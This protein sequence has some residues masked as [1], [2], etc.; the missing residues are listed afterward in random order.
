MSVKTD[1]EYMLVREDGLE[2]VIFSSDRLKEVAVFCNIPYDTSKK[3]KCLNR[4][5]NFEGRP[6]KIIAVDLKADYGE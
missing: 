5:F 1:Y 3:N 2:E 6:V 4:V